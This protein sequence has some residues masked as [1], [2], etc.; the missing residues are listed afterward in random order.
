LVIAHRLNT[1]YNSD[2]ILL[3]ENG[4]VKSFEKIEN[5]SDN[6]KEYFQ[7]YLKSI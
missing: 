5:L 1:I 6:E 4:L 2:K 7:N 3:L